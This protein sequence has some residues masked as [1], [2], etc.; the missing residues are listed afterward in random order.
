MENEKF[1]DR[2][3]IEGDLLDEYEAILAAEA[4]ST[5]PPMTEEDEELRELDGWED[6]LMSVDGT[7]RL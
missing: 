7:G 4:N 6:V 1:N 3:E 2:I 5:P